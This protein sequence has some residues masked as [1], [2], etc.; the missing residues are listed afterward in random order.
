MLSIEAWLEEIMPVVTE[1]KVFEK[2]DKSIVLANFV[3]FVY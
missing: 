1:K 3:H 2:Q